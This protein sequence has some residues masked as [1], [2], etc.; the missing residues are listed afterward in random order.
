VYIGG[1]DPKDTNHTPLRP[2]TFTLF[3]RANRLRNIS[4]ANRLSNVF[5]KPVKMDWRA[6][7]DNLDQDDAY[8]RNTT[9]GYNGVLYVDRDLNGSWRNETIKVN[10][11][12]FYRGHQRTN[13]RLTI[14][15]KG[16]RDTIIINHQNSEEDP[17]EVAWRTGEFADYIDPIT[18]DEWIAYGFDRGV[19]H[20]RHVTAIGGPGKDTFIA[21][22]TGVTATPIY[23]RDMEIGEKLITHR[24]NASFRE[25]PLNTDTHNNWYVYIDGSPDYLAARHRLNLPENTRLEQMFNAE[26]DAVYMCVPDNW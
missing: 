16:G 12:G 17:D 6:A 19:Q 5:R 11:L 13:N 3:S 23:I 24:S 7:F 15:A 18:V 21:K 26:G 8:V 14:D 22:G 4:K 9:A 20:L 25:D 10:Q 2:M 1:G